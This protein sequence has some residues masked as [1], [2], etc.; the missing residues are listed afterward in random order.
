MS[1]KQRPSLTSTRTHQ[2]PP[3]SSKQTISNF[4]L[5]MEKPCP[6][7]AQSINARLNQTGNNRWL[8]SPSINT[9]RTKI[10]FLILYPGPLEMPELP[11]NP[12]W[13]AIHSISFRSFSHTQGFSETAERDFTATEKETQLG[14]TTERLVNFDLVVWKHP[15]VHRKKNPLKHILQTKKCSLFCALS[16]C[17]YLFLSP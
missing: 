9:L 4:W 6:T 7:W 3:N 16:L 2:F 8:K 15:L 5:K 11:H 12:H 13:E 1:S 17:F 10:S 14:S